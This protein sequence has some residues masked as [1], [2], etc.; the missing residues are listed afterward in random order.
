MGEEKQ[1]NG[2]GGNVDVEKVLK[3][4][5]AGG[6]LS[7]ALVLMWSIQANV[8]DLT[9]QF[10]TLNQRVTKVTA[11]L[12]VVSP[13]DVRQEVVALKD[14]LSPQADANSQRLRTL[15]ERVARIETILD[16]MG[17]CTE[18]Y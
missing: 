2:P 6:A 5:G 9:T 18:A 10:N 8:Q 16:S 17:M 1:K 12:E 7:L 11:S 15:E 3:T 13:K 4:G 14:A